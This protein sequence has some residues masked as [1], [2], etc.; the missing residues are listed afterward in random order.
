MDPWNVKDAC[1]YVCMRELVPASDQV[2][3]V[4]IPD[5]VQR[6]LWYSKED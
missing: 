5:A 4:T 6:Y 1:M 2:G 3:L